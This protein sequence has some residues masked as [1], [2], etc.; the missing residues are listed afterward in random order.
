MAKEEKELLNEIVDSVTEMH[1]KVKSMKGKKT[2]EV[3]ITVASILPDVIRQVEELG[4]RLSSADK[5]ALAIEVSLKYCNIK[6]LPD[7]IESK[8]IG[9]MIDGSVS[10]LNKWF[11]KD[12]IDKI[13]KVTST[14]WG[15]FKKV[16]GK[17]N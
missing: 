16:F 3:I 14:V 4:D 1:G 8:I 5:R 2:A 15:W 7:A 12:W 13:V 11:G 6:Y 10:M 9:A 17:S